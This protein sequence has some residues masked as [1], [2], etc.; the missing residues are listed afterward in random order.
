[1]VADDITNYSIGWHTLVMRFYRESKEL[2]KDE[3]TNTI[4]N[5]IISAENIQVFFMAGNDC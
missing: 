4:S 1:M 2:T 3:I 5:I